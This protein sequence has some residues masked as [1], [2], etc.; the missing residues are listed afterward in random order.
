[1][2]ADDDLDIEAQI[3]REVAE[4]QGN[5]TSADSTKRKQRRFE[6]RRTDTSCLIFIAVAPPLDPVVL[7][8][9]AIRELLETRV[10]RTKLVFPKVQSI[11][12]IFTR[13]Y[14]ERM[15]SIISLASHLDTFKDSHQSLKCAHRL[16]LHKLKPWL[17]KFSSRR[18]P[19]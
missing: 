5:S 12:R 11:F 15:Y 14:S 9:E 16:T 6:S 10:C 18:W 3:A 1:M 7:V 8:Q 4:I 19:A 2:N 17:G 13:A